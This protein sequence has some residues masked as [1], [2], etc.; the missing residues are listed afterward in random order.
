MKNIF[1]CL[2][3][4][5]IIFIMLAYSNISMANKIKIIIKTVKHLKIFFINVPLFFHF[6]SKK[7]SL[8]ARQKVNYF[9]P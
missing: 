1:K 6:R 2:T 5:I 4:F 8:L 3:V 7:F 9:K